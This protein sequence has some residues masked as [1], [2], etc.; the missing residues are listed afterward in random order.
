MERYR[1]EGYLPREEFRAQ[2]ELGLARVAFNAKNWSESEK[3]YAA[4]VKQYPNGAAAPE[5]EY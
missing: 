1:I 2:L 5:A 3:L 4:I